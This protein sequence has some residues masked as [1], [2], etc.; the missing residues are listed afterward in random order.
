MTAGF[1]PGLDTVFDMEE[2]DLDSDYDLAE[3]DPA[4]SQTSP[5][6]PEQIASERPIKAYLVKY[7][8]Y[9]TFVDGS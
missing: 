2:N 9:T 1:P 6:V 5:E 3:E 4:D 7:T 8:S